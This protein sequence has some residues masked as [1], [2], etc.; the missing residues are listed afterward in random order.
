MNQDV[1][2]MQ[3]RRF[4]KKVGIQSQREIE[5]AV[6]QG[7]KSGSLRGDEKLCAEVLFWVSAAGV[8]VTIEGEIT[9]S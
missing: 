1:F 8:E 6:H 7:I 4:L 9:L 2:N 3:T 5:Q